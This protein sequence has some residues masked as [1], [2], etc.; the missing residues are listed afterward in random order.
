M[1]VKFTG[2]ILAALF[3]GLKPKPSLTR[4]CFFARN[5]AENNKKAQSQ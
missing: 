3:H 5:E 2:Y 1:E 4:A